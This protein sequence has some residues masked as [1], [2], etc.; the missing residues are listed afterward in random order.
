MKRT[1]VL[2]TN[3]LTIITT[4]VIIG[5]VFIYSA[6]SV[7]ALE[8]YGDA[9][10]FVKKQLMGLLLGLGALGAM[11][12][13][14][15]QTIRKYTPFFFI[16][17]LALTAATLI[18]NLSY[19]PI[20]GT[21]INGAHRWLSIGGFLFQPSE[22]LKCATVLFVAHY[23]DRKRFQLTSFWYGYLP[24]LCIIGAPCA[25]LLLQPD[26]GQ[27]VTL[28]CTALCLFFIANGSSKHLTITAIA[29]LLG[30]SILIYF[31]SYRLQRLLTFLNP[32]D[33][34]QGKG[35]QIIQSI[36]AIGSGN[37]WG[38]GIMN[39]KQKYFYLPMQHTDF[40]FSI[41]AE[42]TGFIG[43][44]LLITLFIALL[45]TGT[46]LAQSFTNNFAALATY[47]FVLLTS[48]QALINIA[49]ASGLAPTKGIGLPFVSYGN[50]A[51]LC[52]FLMLG[53]IINS[54]LEERG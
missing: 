16:G 51:L 30:A 6:S 48:L 9:G 40:I 15:S 29:G 22:L 43:V 45:L 50:S 31:K 39:S 18:P 4:L 5:F 46:K 14:P 2:L 11:V 23:I 53:I 35:F 54:V 8:L 12:I 44:L 52:N 27:A 7:Y 26:F 33:D 47:G 25:L 24:F 32:W 42:E 21:T 34:P 1:T 10:Y 37:L 3:F 41:F 19:L 36:I 38:A 20:H 17:T 49:V 13:L 28:S